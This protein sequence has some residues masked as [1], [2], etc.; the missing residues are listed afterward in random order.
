MEDELMIPFVIV[1]CIVYG[2]LALM[3]IA[4]AIWEERD[5]EKRRKDSIKEVGE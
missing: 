3:G 2:L 4:Y 5:Y 1:P